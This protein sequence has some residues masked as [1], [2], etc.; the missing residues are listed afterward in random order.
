[1]VKLPHLQKYKDKALLILFII[2]N[3]IFHYG[4]I[5]LFGINGVR[6][7]F[8]QIIK[9]PDYKSSIFIMQKFNFSF[10]EN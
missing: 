2:N 10:K 1:M 4:G 7:R 9:L 3:Y 6:R 5:S 8:K